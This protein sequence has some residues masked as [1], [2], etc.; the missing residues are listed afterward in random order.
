MDDVDQGGIAGFVDPAKAARI[1]DVARLAG[2]S[3]A[4]V[5]RAL[6]SPE[7][8]SPDT[9]A[10]VTEAIAQIGYVPNPAARTLR[11]AVRR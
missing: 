4:T 8:V 6:A 10:R 11:F 5:S 7:R 2:V 1:Q 9:R 3:T